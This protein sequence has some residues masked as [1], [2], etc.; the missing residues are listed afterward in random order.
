MS[1]HKRRRV[2]SQY[3]IST[4]VKIFFREIIIKIHISEAYRYPLNRFYYHVGQDRINLF[5]KE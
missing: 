3:I 1:T 4:L 5:Y 2:S